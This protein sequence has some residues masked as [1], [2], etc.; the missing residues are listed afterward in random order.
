MPSGEALKTYRR[1]IQ[2]GKKKMRKFRNLE[3]YTEAES[4][5]K[6]RFTVPVF[7]QNG[8][9]N[10]A[11]DDFEALTKALKTSMTLLD[12]AKNS[13]VRAAVHK[14]FIGG[15]MLDYNDHATGI[16]YYDNDDNY[17]GQAV[18][19]CVSFRP[20]LGVNELGNIDYSLDTL[21]QYCYQI[22]EPE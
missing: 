22:T 20:V 7:D 15:A 2:G 14:V 10:P 16:A 6:K 8:N 12:N 21:G 4:F 3:N 18:E 9:L 19:H 11:Y 1:K 17:L 13:A 5:L